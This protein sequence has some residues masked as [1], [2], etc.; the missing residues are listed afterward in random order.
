MILRRGVDAP[1]GAPKPAVD[2]TFRVLDPGQGP[3]PPPSL[4]DWLP[5]EHLARFI[6]K[7]VDEHLEL[8]RIRAAYTR[9]VVAHR[10]TRG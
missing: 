6:A 2:K 4:D 3:L 10:M 7:M 5:A 8:W 1:S 9:E